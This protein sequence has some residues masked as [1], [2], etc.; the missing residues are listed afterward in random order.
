[1][2][3]NFEEFKKALDD[4]VKNPNG[5]FARMTKKLELKNNRQDKFEVWLKT[6]DF[7]PVF[8]KLLERNGQERSDK[9]YK[10]GYE[11]YGTPLM[12]FLCGYITD[13]IDYVEDHKFSNDFS[14][15]VWFFENY[16]FQLI[17]GQ[18]C[19]WRIYDKKLK[20]IED[21]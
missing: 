20:H 14:S 10:N 4:D 11:K 18:G 3:I 12:E 6:N 7:E 1:M 13:R 17:C 8:K 19:F 2:S 15:G 9:C 16:W 21:V 5:S